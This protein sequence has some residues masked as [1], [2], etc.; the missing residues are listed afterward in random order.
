MSDVRDRLN[1]HPIKTLNGLI[2][3]IKKELPLALSL[4]K[5]RYSKSQLIDHLVMLGGKKL[6]DLSKIPMLPKKKGKPRG[7]AVVKAEKEAKAKSPPKNIKEINKLVSK[8]S[9]KE[10]LL[11]IKKKYGTNSKVVNLEDEAVKEVKDSLEGIDKSSIT[12]DDYSMFTDTLKGEIQIIE[13]S[14]L[15]KD[16][17]SKLYKKVFAKFKPIFAKLV[18]KKKKT[19]IIKIKKKEPQAKQSQAKQSEEPKKKVIIIKKKKPRTEKQLANDKKLGENAK[20]KAADKKETKSGSTEEIEFNEIAGELFTNKYNPASI[21][22]R[23]KSFSDRI[24]LFLK[25][26]QIQEDV[27]NKLFSVPPI[28]REKLEKRIKSI[29]RSSK[30]LKNLKT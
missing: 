26:T 4:N 15:N 20:K 5:K 3:G 16:S 18:E 6:I 8:A 27:Q 11:E 25:I 28:L 2:R 14:G 29:E 21:E 12:I 19:T 1:S 7:N 24:K 9:T 23:I 17:R 10:E 22:K 13:K 30:K